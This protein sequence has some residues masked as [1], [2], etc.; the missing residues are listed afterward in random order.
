MKNKI[1]RI[2][3]GAK[4][5][6][7]SLQPRGGVCKAIG[8]IGF[9]VIIIAWKFDLSRRKQG[10]SNGAVMVSLPCLTRLIQIFVTS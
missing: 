10:N 9:I 2:P 7:D 8:S 6:L 1:K 5:F 4:Q 3:K